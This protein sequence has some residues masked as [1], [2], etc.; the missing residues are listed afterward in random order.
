MKTKII[1]LNRNEIKQY[2]IKMSRIE[3]KQIYKKTM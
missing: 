2:E 1:Y 3:I